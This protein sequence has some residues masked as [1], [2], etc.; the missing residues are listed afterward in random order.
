MVFM[1]IDDAFLKGDSS[2][3][4]TD[5]ISKILRTMVPLGFLPHPVKSHLLPLQSVEVLGFVLNSVLMSITI[6]QGKADH[7]YACIQD[8]L[9]AKTLTIRELARV[10]SKVLTCSPAA[11]LA[12]MNY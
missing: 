7:V 3:Q 5:A 6:S 1:Y 12:L 9:C 8:S 11:P 2:A 4:C 10:T